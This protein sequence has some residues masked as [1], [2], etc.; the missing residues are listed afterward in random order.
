L[1]GVIT[2]QAAMIAYLDD[3]RLMFIMTVVSIPLLLFV[4]NA[5]PSTGAAHVAIE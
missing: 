2:A 5:R 3:F 4:R 1:N